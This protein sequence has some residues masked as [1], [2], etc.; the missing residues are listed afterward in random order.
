V[1]RWRWILSSLTRQAESNVATLARFHVLAEEFLDAGRFDDVETDIAA[2][3]G[4]FPVLRAGDGVGHHSLNGE[5]S[6]DVDHGERSH[7]TVQ[8][9]Q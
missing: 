9:L 5:R 8:F 4:R 2:E 1:R 7:R 3:S 6:A